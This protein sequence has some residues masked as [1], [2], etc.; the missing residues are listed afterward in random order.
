[1]QILPWRTLQVP[2]HSVSRGMMLMKDSQNLQCFWVIGINYKKTD[3][4]VRGLFA[5]NTDQ[6]DYL[7]SV[8]GDYGV[9]ELFILSTC[10]RTELYGVADDAEQLI[11][12]LCDVCA[13]DVAIFKSIAYQK[14]G[15][16]A[17]EHLFRVAAGLDSQIL[18]DFEIL[19]QIKN[20]VK[21]SKAAGFI[22]PFLDRLL[23]CVLK[24][25]KA[26]KTNTKLSGGTVSVSFAAIQFIRERIADISDKKIVV[27]GAGKIG[28]I[29]CKN[30]VKYLDTRQITLLNRTV[31]TAEAIAGELGIAFGGL[32]QFEAEVGQAEIIIVSTN[33]PEPILRK[34]HLQGGAAKIIIDL[35]VPCNVARDVQ[36]LPGVTVVDI[37]VL[38]KIKDDT[39]EVRRAE[40]PKVLEIIQEHLTEFRNW[41]EMRK[42]V[43]VLR[44]VK[45]KLYGIALPLVLMGPQAN[46]DQHT[47]KEEK[48]QSVINVLAAKMRNH[49]AYGCYYIEAINDFIARHE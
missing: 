35:S 10:N 7:L 19:G 41:Q 32:S 29:T 46:A 16:P 48:I 40:V 27:A 3:T 39:L 1:M 11:A 42:H 45:E 37:D 2:L 14:N 22:G 18:G 30:L 15:V 44:A 9:K 49:P 34:V 33:A 25:S 28:R 17:I 8:A 26:V 47:E 43:P 5:I 4:A 23:S 20:A 24:C 12:L 36:E 13:G 6:Y 21:Q 31:E 38:S